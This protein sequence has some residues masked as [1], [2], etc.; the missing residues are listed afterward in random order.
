MGRKKKEIRLKEPVRIREKKIAGGNISLYLDI[1][2]KGLRKKETLKLYLVP[3]INAATKLQNANT[4]KLAEQIKAQRILDIQREGLVDWDKVKKSRMT[5]TKWMD[6]FVKYN[7]ELS[8]SSMKTK[9]NTHAR[10]DQYLLHI[11]KPEFLLKD[12]D[13][14][15]CKGFIT[16][17]KT[18]TYNDGKKQLS[19]TTCRMFVNYF[20]SSLAKAVRDG[21]IEQ[22]PFLLL[23]AKEK[24]QKRVAEREFLT[25]EEIKKVM[26]T[27]CRYELVKKAFLFSCFTGLRYSDMKAL[28]WSEIHK[29]ADG[30]T[31]YIDHIQVKTKDR[32]TIPL[33]EETKKWMPKREEGIDNIFHNLTITSTTVEV[34][35]KEWMEAAGITKLITYHCSSHN[36]IFY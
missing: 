24:P 33:S 9:R 12:V 5:L 35:L 1:Y 19:T 10:I 22:N 3:E 25:I 28:N 29:A 23:E 7:A 18:C 11:G 13:K 8:E 26:N 31:E 36:K 27:P 14:E 15:F 34:V 17:L 6:D 4:R 2:Q 21:L 32:V 30:K 20:G 16:F